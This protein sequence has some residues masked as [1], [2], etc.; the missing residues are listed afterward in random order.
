LLL[1]VTGSWVWRKLKEKWEGADQKLWSV[2]GRREMFWNKSHGT[3]IVIHDN[4]MY[5]FENYHDNL[6]KIFYSTKQ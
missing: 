5:L 2:K 4:L 3:L 1:A 6:F